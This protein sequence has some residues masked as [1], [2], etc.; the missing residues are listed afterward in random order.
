MLALSNSYPVL[1]NYVMSPD[2]EVWQVTEIISKYKYRIQNFNTDVEKVVHLSGIKTLVKIIERDVNYVSLYDKVVLPV[3]PW[4]I[5]IV[6]TVIG[7]NDEGIVLEKDNFIIN[8]Q[9]E[10]HIKDFIVYVVDAEIFDITS[11]NMSLLSEIY[12]MNISDE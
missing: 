2:G 12:E 7:F 3:P 5:P 8:Q 4:P 10:E 9:L 6:F 11:Y 1:D